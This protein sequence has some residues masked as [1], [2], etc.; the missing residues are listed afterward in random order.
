VVPDEDYVEEVIDWSRGVPRIAVA[1]VYRSLEEAFRSG[2][3]VD[4]DAVSAAAE[5]LGLVGMEKEVY[6]IPES[7]LTV[8][9]RMLLDTD[10]RGMQ[11]SKL[12]DLLNKDKSTVSYHLRELR[13]A[14]IVES[15]RSGRRAFYSIREAVKPIVQSR[16]VQQGEI[17][18]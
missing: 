5:K 9:T 6:S 3:E 11:P 7:R 17:H 16:V 15:E 12:V 10:E 18:G 4:S 13:D 2:R 8:L 1:L 14:E